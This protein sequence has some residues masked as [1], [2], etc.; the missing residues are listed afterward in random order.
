MHCGTKIN[1]RGGPD[2]GKNEYFQRKGVCR[3]ITSFQ[4]QQQQQHFLREFGCALVVECKPLI[5][6]TVHSVNKQ[7]NYFVK[8]TFKPMKATCVADDEW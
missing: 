2:G 1:F 7:K 8:V 6:C 5:L 3:L 4:L